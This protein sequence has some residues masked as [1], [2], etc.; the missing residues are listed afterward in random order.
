MESG[1][2]NGDRRGSGVRG[3]HWGAG[4]SRHDHGQ[5][6]KQEEGL[7]NPMPGPEVIQPLDDEDIPIVDDLGNEFDDVEDWPASSEAYWQEVHEAHARQGRLIQ[8]L[9]RCIQLMRD[10]SPRQAP[11]WPKDRVSDEEWLASARSAFGQVN[12]MDRDEAKS[13]GGSP[14]DKSGGRRVEKGSDLTEESSVGSWW[15]KKTAATADFEFLSRL[16][17]A[18]AAWALLLIQSESAQRKS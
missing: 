15:A 5:G 3:W 6:Q 1:T 13:R 18:R 7:G 9:M 11:A 2:A 4:E 8:K 12:D 17:A 16:L 10:L 14:I